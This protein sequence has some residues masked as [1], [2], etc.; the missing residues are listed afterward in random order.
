[1]SEMNNKLIAKRNQSHNA[2]RGLAVLAAVRETREQPGF[3]LRDHSWR[4]LVA[5]SAERFPRAAAPSVVQQVVLSKIALPY[6]RDIACD[7]ILA[8]VA[9]IIEHHRK[10]SGPGKLLEDMAA[11]VTEIAKQ[12]GQL[13]VS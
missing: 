11:Y 8:G 7:V 5:T 13:L 6:N 12:D 10:A 1:M 2:P 3:S 4:Q 9:M